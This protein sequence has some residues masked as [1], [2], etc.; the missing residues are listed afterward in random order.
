M[1]NSLSNSLN[2][3]SSASEVPSE[4]SPIDTRIFPVVLTSPKSFFAHMGETSG[5]AASRTRT[6]GVRSMTPAIETAERAK[7]TNRVFIVLKGYSR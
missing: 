4:L 5:A 6:T 3:G 7:S 2:Y 1:D